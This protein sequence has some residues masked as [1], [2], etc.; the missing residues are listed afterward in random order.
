MPFV[1]QGRNRIK[2]LRGL[3]GLTLAD[4]ATPLRVSERTVNRWELHENEIPR[5]HWAPLAR[6]LR[7]QVPWLLGIE[8]T[9]GD[10]NGE[11][12]EKAA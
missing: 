8:S 7:V 3:R 10:A 2:E 4:V 5:K 6:L 9:D 1:S 12:E 11:C